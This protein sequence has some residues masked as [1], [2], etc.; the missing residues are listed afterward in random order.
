M[1]IRNLEYEMICRFTQANDFMDRE[2]DMLSSTAAVTSGTAFTT[3]LIHNII[4]GLATL[5]NP[6][7]V[8]KFID[9]DDTEYT[10]T[11][12]VADFYETETDLISESVITN[13]ITVT[14]DLYLK[15]GMILFNRGGAQDLLTVLTST[16]LRNL[17]ISV[18]DGTSK[19]IPILSAGGN[20]TIQTKFRFIVSK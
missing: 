4:L 14:S 3:E 12:T 11:S 20:L 9:T 18:L 6:G 17:D 7:Y 16:Q 13:S 15:T 10:S 5:S 8:A 19:G 2:V 1:L